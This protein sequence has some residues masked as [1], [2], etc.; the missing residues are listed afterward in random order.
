MIDNG[1]PN[2]PTPISIPPGSITKGNF[3]YTPSKLIDNSN[4]TSVQPQNKPPVN[5]G[6][7]GGIC[8]IS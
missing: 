2:N 1:Q 5:T 3:N 7:G 4:R 6:P 8:V